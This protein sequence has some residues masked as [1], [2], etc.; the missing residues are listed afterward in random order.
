M[1]RGTKGTI[2]LLVVVVAAMFATSA[3]AGNGPACG[4][5]CKKGTAVQGSLV[6]PA[7]GN[8]D[9]PA[10][11]SAGQLPFT[12]LDLGFIVLAG[13]VLVGVGLG[14]HRM[15]RKPPAPPAA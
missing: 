12:G 10:A 8:V 1:S 2:L 15:A 13:V 11:S 6:P 3:F 7:A 4:V 14:L 9:S 5:Y